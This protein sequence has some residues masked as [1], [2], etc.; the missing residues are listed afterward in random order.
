MLKIGKI[1]Y[2]NVYPFFSALDC[3]KFGSKF[4]EG[5]P[6]ILNEMLYNGEIDVSPSSSFEYIRNPDNYYIV[7]GLS[8]SSRE[9]VLSVNLLLKKKIDEIEDDTIYLTP[10]S[11]TSNELVKVIFKEFYNKKYIKFQML[12]QN[13]LSRDNHLLIGDSALK[14]YFAKPKGFFIY[15]V[16]ELWYKFTGLP[17]VFA[18]WL[19]NGKNKGSDKTKEINR[20]VTALNESKK[21]FE[22][23][24][25]Y[26][27]F[28]FAQLKEYFEV[29]DYNLTDVHIESLK[30]F[31][32]LLYK[33]RIIN[34]TIVFKWWE[35]NF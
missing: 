2:L 30:L 13:A 10:S 7:K 29:I 16:A 4:I 24:K 35:D 33:H 11:A 22:I 3:L 18:L 21:H 1:S 28:T 15:D 17:F 9:K 32:M 25:Q 27:G 23:P 34:E 31:T 20:L 5:E 12:K 19:V 14:V 6:S 26:K 8:V